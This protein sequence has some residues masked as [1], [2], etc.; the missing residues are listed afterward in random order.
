MKSSILLFSFLIILSIRGFSQDIPQQLSEERLLEL[1]K[2]YHPLAQQ[3]QLL[4]RKGES[5]LRKAKG[6][7]D[8]YLHGELN[9]KYYDSKEYYN[10]LNGGLKIP[11]WY[12]IEV[13]TGFE[14]NKGV[15][16]N[17]ER[18]LPDQGLIYAG[19]SLPI[20]QG[21]FIDQRRATLKQARL[22]SK[23]SVIEQ[24]KWI[25]DLLFD[26]TKAYWKWTETW[27]KLQIY[28]E[29]VT[30]AQ[31]R[32]VAV[33]QSFIQGDKP[34]IDT[35]EAFIQVQNRQI[36]QNQAELEYTN[37]TLALSNFL[38]YENNTPLEI[39]D[40]LTPPDIDTQDVRTDLTQDSL[41]TI[42]EQLGETHPEI[43]L[44]QYKLS[45]LS[46]ERKLK[47]E[48]LKPQLNINYNF[49]NE[50]VGNRTITGFNTQD[51]KW[52]ISGSFPL[53]LRKQRGDLQLTKIKI[54]DTEWGQKQK[55]LEV[56]NKV[57][58]YFNAQNNISQQINLYQSAVQNYS[59]LLNGEKQ[60]FNSGE[61]SLFLINSRE[62]KLIE[63][64]T[65]LMSSITKFNIS[66]LGVFWASGLL[67]Q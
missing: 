67:Y 14:Q 19:V 51:Y 27:N 54:S 56:S 50:P 23:A 58:W 45:D 3:A 33:K 5:K 25:N 43:Q 12:G 48:R 44:Y 52:G 17:P 60:K 37:T 41:N 32:F 62:V 59:A 65:K 16:A 49:L 53:F 11:T 30:L 9:Q 34:A 7:F 2:K 8:P 39:T 13:K 31:T 21:L 55:L 6:G 20:G 15:Y 10:L 47:A 63:A 46:I 1:V 61:S 18:K 22:F 38:W 36:L 64:Q 42:L 28:K 4:I 66:K 29:G 35:L 26:A 40:N 24:K 57:K